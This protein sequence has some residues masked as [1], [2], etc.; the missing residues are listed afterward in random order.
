MERKMTSGNAWFQE[1]CLGSDSEL[2]IQRSRSNTISYA[3]W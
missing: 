1:V 3:L 2:E